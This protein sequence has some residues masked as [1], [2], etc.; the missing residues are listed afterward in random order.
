MLRIGFICLLIFLDVCHAQAQIVDHIDSSRILLDDP[1]YHF[2]YKKLI[3]PTVFIGYG[4]A[5][6]ICPSLKELNS[7]TRYETR[8]HITVGAVIDNYMQYAPAG[9]VYGLNIFGV[10][11]KHNL[12]D[13][14]MIYLTS[15]VYMGAMVIPT[16]R[17]VGEIRPDG[18]NTR[19]F[20]SGHTATAF[21][22]AQF[23]FHE[24]RD[25]NFWLSISGYPLAAAT[26]IYR[27]FNDR[28][29]VGDVVAGA[30]IGIL[31]TELAYWT[32]PMTSQLFN[33]KHHN[34]TT[35]ISPYYQDHALG[36]QLAK[37]F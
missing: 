20:P 14:T 28:H 15:Q 37:V 8:E 16:K 33:R 24:Y 11:G 9:A 6:L 26:G 10:K 32:Y 1:A 12:K 22:S 27:I 4:V 35:F 17:W 34:S 23:L 21:S 18:S 2:H 5:S 3:I 13:R 19:S 25:N 36:I 29:W 30:G 31:S 7:S